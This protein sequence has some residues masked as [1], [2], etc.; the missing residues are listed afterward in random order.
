MPSIVESR[1]RYR[2]SSS[3]SS[4]SFSDYTKADWVIFG[5]MMGVSVL[6]TL[7]VCLR[8]FYRRRMGRP[9]LDPK[10]T[11]M[12]VP[13]Q[14][15]QNMMQVNSQTGFPGAAATS[16]T[17]PYGNI[18]EQQSSSYPN[19]TSDT[20]M[21]SYSNT[22]SGSNQHQPSSYYTQGEISMPDVKH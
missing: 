8:F 5:V 13:Q 14:S 9:F 18:A 20:S 10:W 19:M 21:N 2:S 6:C 22:N 12:F 1:R 7:G 16:N 17:P 11:A 15:G 4:K 3:G